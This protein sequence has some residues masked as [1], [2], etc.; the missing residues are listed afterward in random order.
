[1]SPREITPVVPGHALAVP[2]VLGLQSPLWC[3]GQRM[4]LLPAS[5]CFL[6]LYILETNKRFLLPLPDDIRDTK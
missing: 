2:S 1:M 5:L 3:F 6:T 4:G